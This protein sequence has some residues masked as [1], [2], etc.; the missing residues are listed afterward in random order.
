MQRPKLTF[1]DDVA[2]YVTE[3]YERHDSILEYG[4]GGSTVLASEL[5][6]KHVVSVE[7]D[8]DWA[9]N[10]CAFLEQA[11][12][13]RSMP[14]VHHIDV[15]ETGAWGRPV[16]HDK[17]HLF[18]W[19]A[20]APWV[21]QSDRTPQV[22]LVLVDGRFRPACFLASMAMGRGELELIFDDYLDRPKYHFIEEYLRPE[23]SIGRAAVFIRDPE[24]DWGEIALRHQDAF[25][26][27]N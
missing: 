20:L 7:S 22:S 16:N 23:K 17:L 3:A 15:G 19:Y 18:P 8:R 13:V 25:Y 26:D 14:R 27:V 24:T 10:L 21:M 4:S 1:P 5:E 2:K 11:A 12:A 9:G 6:G